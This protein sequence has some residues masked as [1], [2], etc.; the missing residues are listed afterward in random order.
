MSY[1][2]G[3][4]VGYC[5]EI[6][7]SCFCGPIDRPIPYGHCVAWDNGRGDRHPEGSGTALSHVGGVGNIN[8]IGIVHKNRTGPRGITPI[9]QRQG[10]STRE[11]DRKGFRNL[12]FPVINRRD[13]D[14]LGRFTHIESQGAGLGSVITP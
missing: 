9:G 1:C 3:Q 6:E 7:V 5:R 11:I 8:G 13:R 12:H 10:T 2:K 14:V 4:S